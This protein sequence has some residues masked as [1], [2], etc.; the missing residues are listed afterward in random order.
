[1]EDLTP[2]NSPSLDPL[3]KPCPVCGSISYTW[4]RTVGESPSQY[5]YFRA[6][7]EGW[8]GGKRLFARECN[9]CGNVQMFTRE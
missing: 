4:G 7:A 9:T 1:M 6:E 5:V 8:G 2:K 3:R